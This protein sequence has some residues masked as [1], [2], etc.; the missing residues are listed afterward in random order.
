MTPEPSG[1]GLGWLE[2]LCQQKEAERACAILSA[3]LD[4]WEVQQR[5]GT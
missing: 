1:A 2:R 3:E 4:D 5:S